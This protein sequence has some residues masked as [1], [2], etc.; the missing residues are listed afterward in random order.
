MEFDNSGGSVYHK[1]QALYIR[2]LDGQ[3]NRIAGPHQQ[4][5]REIWQLIQPQL[6]RELGDISATPRS[7]S[8]TESTGSTPVELIVYESPREGG[9][10]IFGMIL[11]TPAC[12]PEN[13]FQDFFVK[14]LLKQMR[15]H[16]EKALEFSQI[17]DKPDRT[18]AIVD[19][20]DNYLRHTG[21]QDQWHQGGRDYFE[22][23]VR[24]FT[25]RNAKVEFCLP[26]FPCKSSNPEK[27][28]GNLPDRGEEMALLR[29]HSFVREIEAIYEPGAKVWIISDGHVF[30]DCIGVD[31]DMVDRYTASLVAM[32][33]AIDP[34]NGGSDRVGFKSLVDL[35][36]LKS[37]AAEV[38]SLNIPEIDHFLHT[39]VTEEAEL[40]R[41]VL[42]SGCQSEKAN[43]RRRIDAQEPSILALYRG[44]SRFMLEDLDLHPYTKPMTR[45]QRK[46]LSIK[47]SF[48]MIMR[49]QAYSNLVELLFPDHVRLS[50]H[51]HTNS[52]P[53]FG[54]RLFDKHLVK[55]VRSLEDCTETE[56]ASSDLLHI[57]TPWHNCMFQFADDPKVYVAKSKI[58]NDALKAGHVGGGW[59][60]WGEGHGK[61]FE[62][63]KLSSSEIDSVVPHV[64]MEEKVKSMQLETALKPGTT[65][66]SAHTSSIQI[67]AKSGKVGSLFSRLGT[68]GVYVLR[69]GGV[70][71]L[72]LG[73]GLYMW[74]IRRISARS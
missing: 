47:V 6:P 12:E 43:L 50:I 48:E 17:I 41:K 10:A 25:S 28:M 56:G 16:A 23:R 14:L 59:V 5:M 63:R 57:P 29:L 54:V 19:L 8:Y 65:P 62:I 21:T 24:H 67:G 31:D 30:S 69:L 11:Q 49:N 70:A 18:R 1:T 34:N 40:S 3:L 26:A 20:F 52:G 37:S 73:T 4:Q 61:C 68:W 13:V 39:K 32:N 72:G 64:E 58:I 38:A 60:E 27:V 33:E 2:S 51:A 46:K 22:G 71:V 53:K 44:F 9:N 7:V 42:M 15:L 36:D 74:S 45:S 55:T 66:M 35:F